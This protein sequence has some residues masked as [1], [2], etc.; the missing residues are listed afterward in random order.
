MLIDEETVY[1]SL[2]IFELSLVFF[3]LISN[4]LKSGIPPKPTF[5]TIL[6]LYESMLLR[7]ISDA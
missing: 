3:K 1:Y 2:F 7:R 6:L 4:G 5:A